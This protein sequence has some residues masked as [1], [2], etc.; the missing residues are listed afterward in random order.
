M[1]VC[2]WKNGTRCKDDIKVLWCHFYFG[3]L[4]TP[5][6]LCL[7]SCENVCLLFWGGVGGV[8]G[9]GGC[10][11]ELGGCGGEYVLLYCLLF[12]AVRWA[13]GSYA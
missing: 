7:F 13:Y 10:G 9:V 3:C 8:G 2:G 1:C 4:G 5:S 6:L 12:D 11:G